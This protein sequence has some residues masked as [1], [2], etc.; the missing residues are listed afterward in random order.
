MKVVKMRSNYKSNHS[1]DVCGFEEIEAAKLVSDGKAYYYDTATDSVDKSSKEAR[2][3]L[4]AM[5][6][7]QKVDAPDYDGM[8]WPKLKSAAFAKAAERG[9]DLESL[10]PNQE[11]A[12]LL[13]YLKSE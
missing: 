1:G 11:T 7:A 6:D 3:K 12:S 9:D 5:A 13:A 4:K 2:K 8:S 10:L